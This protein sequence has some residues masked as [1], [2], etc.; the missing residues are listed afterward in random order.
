MQKLIWWVQYILKCPKFQLDQGK[1][2][3]HRT[4]WTMEEN[5]EDYFTHWNV[6]LWCPFPW[7]DPCLWHV[8]APWCWYS[9][10]CQ[11]VTLARVVC[12]KYDDKS[13]FV[14]F[15]LK[16]WCTGNKSSK[17]LHYH[18]R[19]KLSICGWNRFSHYS[20]YFSNI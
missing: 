1:K 11:L 12:I 3:L 5:S 2:W 19:S 4:L 14:V 13:V 7:V 8:I 15:L 6:T 17:S 16:S 9:W 20:K 18:H 10:D